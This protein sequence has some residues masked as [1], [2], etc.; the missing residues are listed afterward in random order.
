MPKAV[1]KG[2]R[3]NAMTDPYG[4]EEKPS[5]M[6]ATPNFRASLTNARNRNIIM[7][8]S[9]PHQQGSLSSKNV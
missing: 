4:R 5:V 1:P 6:M 7:M 9:G 8:D 3:S 2:L